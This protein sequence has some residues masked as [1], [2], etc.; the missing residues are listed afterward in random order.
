VPQIE[1]MIGRL[2]LSFLGFEFSDSGAT[3]ERYRARFPA[4]PYL[5]NMGNWN[6]L[7]EEFPDTF[8]RMYQFWVRA[9]GE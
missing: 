8:A 5:L 2:G 7:E 1:S 4:D 3:V 6:K 9:A